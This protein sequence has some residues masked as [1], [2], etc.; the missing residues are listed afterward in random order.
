MNFHDAELLSTYLDGQL[1]PSERARVEA[2]LVTDA[3]MRRLL[4]D[5]QAT[6]TL[7]RALPQ[8]KAPRNFTLQPKKQRLVAPTPRAFPVLRFASVL[9]SAIFLGTVAL[10]GLAPLA[11]NRLAAAPAA[12]YGMGGGGAPE[13]VATPGPTESAQSLLAGA[14]SAPPEATTLPPNLQ[15][16]QLKTAPQPPRA[17]PQPASPLI[18]ISLQVPLIALAVL[19]G[20]GAWLTQAVTTRRFRRRWIDKADR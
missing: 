15:A 8:R 10:N 18:P 17:S 4:A 13:A 9:A 14:P 20:A 1:G 5:L 2:R 3:E 11:A 19:L 7:L 16:P 12:S 6:R